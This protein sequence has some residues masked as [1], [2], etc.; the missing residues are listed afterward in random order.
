MNQ[1]DRILGLYSVI[2][3]GFKYIY[4]CVSI[5]AD[6]LSCYECTSEKSWDDCNSKMAKTSCPSGS[7]QCLSGTL[8]CTAGEEK[9]TVY[10]KRC[11]KN[12]DCET[13]REDSPTCPSSS[14]SWNFY[15]LTSCCSGDNCNSGTSHSIN[16]AMLA[17]C[18]ALT[19]LALAFIH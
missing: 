11:S 17:I 1:V 19:L 4:F 8:S 15:S 18:M 2:D 10:Y 12:D 7:P 6:S 3:P 13:T 5:L 16:R 9:K 14:M